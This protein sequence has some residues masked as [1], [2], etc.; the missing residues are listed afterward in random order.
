[1][2][3]SPKSCV[4]VKNNFFFL[5][6][7]NSVFQMHTQYFMLRRPRSLVCQVSK[8]ILKLFLKSSKHDHMYACIL[9]KI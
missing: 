2:Y 7:I 6:E 4:F 5:N 3:C 9:G 1:M 8:N